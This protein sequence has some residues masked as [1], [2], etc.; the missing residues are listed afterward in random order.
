MK[1]L[2]LCALL[3]QG[4]SYN[5]TWDVEQSNP[6]PDPQAGTFK[7]TYSYWGTVALGKPEQGDWAEYWAASRQ[8]KDWGYDE[9]PYTPNATRMDGPTKVCGYNPSGSSAPGLPR[10]CAIWY[11][12]SHWRCIK[13]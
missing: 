1:R 4:C 2:L 12:S 3:L 9:H 5:V 10:S 7:L 8:C 11:V 13:G 6:R